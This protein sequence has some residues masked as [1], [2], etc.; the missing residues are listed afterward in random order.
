[1]SDAAPDHGA[2]RS[3]GPVPPDV[4]QRVQAGLDHLQRAAREVIAAS[5]AL[6]DAAEELV[7]DPRTAAGVADLVRGLAG[8][9][10]PPQGRG[11][12][13]EGPDDGPSVQ[14]IPVS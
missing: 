12:D 13:A 5:R 6:L 8:G 7:E 11:D 10:R 4:D 3:G 14:R 9:L 2:D 1:M